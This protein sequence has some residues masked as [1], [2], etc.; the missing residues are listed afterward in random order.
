MVARRTQWF[1]AVVVVAA[2]AAVGPVPLLGQ[3][4]APAARAAELMKNRQYADAIKILA[5]EV[6]G[7][8]DTAVA[9]KELMLGE[10]YYLITEY[11]KAR[12]YFA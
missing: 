8:D 11:E 1:R 9:V 7:K 5:A 4:A 10:C 2:L 6:E 3:A 12:P